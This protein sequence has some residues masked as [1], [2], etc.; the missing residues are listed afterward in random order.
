MPTWPE[1]LLPGARVSLVAPAGPLRGADE[2]ARAEANARSFGWEPVV[3]AHA[4][5]RRGYL[6]GDDAERAADLNDALRDPRIDGIWCL[7]GGYG[8]MRILEQLDYDALRRRPRPL[9]GFSDVT[10]LH[11]AV[12]ARCDLVT[13][14]APTARGVLSA[15]ARESLARAVVRGE[16]PCG[17]CPDARVLRGGCA[18]GRLEGGNL[19]LITALV[20][21]PFAARLDGAILALEDV[22]EPLYRI[23]RMLVHL[24]LAGAL[25]RLAGLVFGAFTARGDDE[26][27]GGPEPRTLD[28]V[29]AEAAGCVNGPCLAGVPVGHLDDQWTM[30]L[31]ATAELDGGARALRV[32]AAVA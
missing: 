12:R 15:F 5:A 1:P 7:R 25:A 30:P 26:D 9:L 14:H 4:L 27:E 28:D 32:R 21:T 8:A 20:G 3:G 11:L 10:A 13:F 6:A 16:D 23:D 29:L 17:P 18:V 22:N 19:A 2:L 31:G 24:R